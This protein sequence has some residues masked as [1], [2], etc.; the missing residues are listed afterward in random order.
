MHSQ[1]LCI[2]LH[3]TNLKFLVFVGDSILD[4]LDLRGDH[5]EY[6]NVDTIELIET[7]PGPTLAQTGEQLA[8]SLQGGLGNIF[9]V[10][11][12]NLR[13]QYDC[14]AMYVLQT[15]SNQPLPK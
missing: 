7:P 5:R 12:F 2:L 15:N 3:A 4:G 14:H 13:L 6:R 10:Y 11:D 1:L 8:H 9:S